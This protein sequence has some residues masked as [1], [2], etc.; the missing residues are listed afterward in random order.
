M[1]RIS[2][3]LSLT[4]LALPA[5][6]AAQSPTSSPKWALT[7]DFG[8]HADRLAQPERVL[9]G[10]V[11]GDV[12]AEQYGGK[13][14]APTVGLRAT[15]WLGAH[16]GI[17]AGAALARNVAWGGYG[18]DG[19][20]TLRKL[21]LFSSVA[22]VWRVFPPANRFQLQV[23]A[24]PAL[25]TH[26]G[27]GESLLTRATDLGGVAMADVSLRVSRRFRVVLGARN[28][29]FTS[30]FGDTA[31]AGFSGYTPGN[32]ARSEWLIQTGLRVSF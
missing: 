7:F 23:G 5:A 31:P 18:L 2:W 9:Q 14:E 26:L 13:G 3:V 19:G 30:R 8:I 17:D 4:F 21:T 20:K 32:R 27:N 15:R 12:A 24:G 16:L 22:P 10:T 1:K 11:G 29:R 25:V 28:Y 6:A